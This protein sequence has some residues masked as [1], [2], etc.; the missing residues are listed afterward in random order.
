MMDDTL[1][2]PVPS[3]SPATIVI[4]DRVTMGLR[5]HTVALNPA[6]CTEMIACA[7]QRLASTTIGASLFRTV[8][9]SAS[10]SA[11][12]VIWSQAFPRADAL[13]M[14]MSRNTQSRS[15]TNERAHHA[16]TTRVPYCQHLGVPIGIVL[17]D[18]IPL[19]QPTTNNNEIN[20]INNI[21]NTANHLL[22]VRAP[23]QE[24]ERVHQQDQCRTAALPRALRLGTKPS[25]IGNRGLRTPWNP[26]LCRALITLP[27]HIPNRPCTTLE[28]PMAAVRSH[29]ASCPVLSRRSSASAAAARAGARRPART[30]ATNGTRSAAAA[31][32]ESGLPRA[33]TIT[34]AA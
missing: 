12:V 13:A 26:L 24:K 21:S 4:D 2:R 29:D 8:L 9:T 19:S 25:A 33:T 11:A 15:R 34:T 1:G 3:G 6:W 18:E 32:C 28:R 27:R 22:G 14:K 7:P 20:N 10:L 16:Q 5:T 23:I 31:P 17:I 30:R